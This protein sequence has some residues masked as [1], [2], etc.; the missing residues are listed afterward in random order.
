MWAGGTAQPYTQM[1]PSHMSANGCMGGEWSLTTPLNLALIDPSDAPHIQ[2]KGSQVGGIAT[3]KARDSQ[4]GHLLCQYAPLSYW[5]RVFWFSLLWLLRGWFGYGGSRGSATPLVKEVGL[6]MQGNEI[7][8]PSGV[9]TGL[10]PW[11]PSPPSPP[12]EG[13]PFLDAELPLTID[14]PGT[15]SAC[16]GKER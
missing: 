12:S 5:S 8:H 11:I 3:S 2:M 14:W 4:G 7:G 6:L 16:P 9:H 15:T 1:D 10:L 13:Q